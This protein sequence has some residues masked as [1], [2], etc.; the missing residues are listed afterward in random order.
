[1]PQ[2]QGA[3]VHDPMFP[4][5]SFTLVLVLTHIAL[6]LESEHTLSIIVPWKL[7]IYIYMNSQVRQRLSWVSK[8][9]ELELLNATVTF[10]SLSTLIDRLMA[11]I[12]RGGYEFLQAMGE[13]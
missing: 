5:L 6:L 4:L 12:L 2:V 11:F 10:K 1:M 8:N 13:M 3:I 7:Y 9:I